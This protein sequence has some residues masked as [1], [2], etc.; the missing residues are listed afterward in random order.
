MKVKKRGEKLVCLGIESTAH[1][2]GIGIV[3]S[4]GRILA[5]VRSMY[6]PKAGKGIVPREASEHHLNKGI[7]IIKTALEEA[8]LKIGDI[9]VVSFAQGPGLP[10]CLRVGAAIARYLAL[11]GNKQL[12]GVNHP[13]GHIEIGKL[14]TGCKDPVILYLS[15]GNTQIIAYAE[16]YYRIFGET[17]DIA[18]GNALDV[19]ARELKLKSP[20]GPEIEK[21]AVGG[22][23]L[24]LPYGVK[25]MDLSFS[26]IVTECK[27]KIAAGVDPKDVCY[28]IQEVCFA[29]L[30]EVTERALAHTGKNEVLL[31][32][33]VAANKRMQEMLKTMCKEREAKL[34]V[35]DLKYS[36]DNGGMIAWLGLLTHISGEKLSIEK[37]IVRQKWRTDEVKIIWVG[38]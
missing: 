28:S 19:V 35:V 21:L 37:S 32:G 25:G 16:G 24:E 30:T 23:Y 31:V 11:S 20:G 3:D 4:E 27:K 38:Y 33:G 29:M 8:G 6:K 10:P 26:G 18:I 36:G 2:F 15:G 17:E 1:T 9:D 5:D 13:V 22:D 7:E 12:V 14:T 34:Y